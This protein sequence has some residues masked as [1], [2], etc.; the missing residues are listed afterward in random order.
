MITKTK[1]ELKAMMTVAEKL[2]EEA[3]K[4]DRYACNTLISV[5]RTWDGQSETAKEAAIACIEAEDC[6]ESD[7]RELRA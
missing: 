7:L 4:A 1:E 3:A 6:T 5:I 2:R